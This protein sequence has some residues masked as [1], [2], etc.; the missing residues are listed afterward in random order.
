MPVR[1]TTKGSRI[2][3]KGLRTFQPSPALGTPAPFP[4]TIVTFDRA[5]FAL[6]D[7]DPDGTVAFVASVND[8]GGTY[9]ISNWRR[10]A[11]FT[12]I[13]ASGTGTTKSFTATGLGSGDIAPQTITVAA[14]YDGAGASGTVSGTITGSVSDHTIASVIHQFTLASTSGGNST[15][16][17]RLG[18]AFEAGD[19]PAGQKLAATVSGASVPMQ[20]VDTATWSDGSLRKATGIVFAGTVPAAGVDVVVGKASGAQGVSSFDPW[21]W[22]TSHAND[23]TVDI[24]NR[25]A[26][27]KQRYTLT[28][29]TGTFTVGESWAYGTATTT[30]RGTVLAWDGTNLDVLVT[31][32]GTFVPA[33]GTTTASA[34]TGMTSAAAGRIASITYLPASPASLAYSLKTAIGTV[35]RREIQE[36]AP[37]FVRAMAWQKVANEE[38]LV[39]IWYLDFWLNA[40]GT[41]PL[42]LEWTVVLS[43]HWAIANPFGVTQ[44]RDRQ[45]YDAVVKYGST[46]VDT[47]TDL[48]HAYHCRWASLRSANDDQHAKKHWVDLSG[49]GTGAMP[50]L[51]HA[52]SEAGLK[53]M[54][55]TGYLPPLRLTSVPTNYGANADGTPPPNGTY[56][57]LGTNGHKPAINGTGGY[58][59]RGA[60][61]VPDARAIITQTAT[62]WRYARAA[63]QGGM[64]VFWHTFDHRTPAVDKLIPEPF[65]QLGAKTYSGLG[66]ELLHG[67][68]YNNFGSLWTSAGGLMV[69]DYTGN[70]GSFTF[71]DY[72]SAH[73]PNYSGLM[74]FIEGERYLQDACLSGFEQVMSYSIYNESGHRKPPAYYDIAARR[75][76]Q[77]I[78]FKRYGIVPDL[79]QE[80]GD[81][82]CM[83]AM[84]WAWALCGDSNPHQAY[85]KNAIIN[86]DKYYKESFDYFPADHLAWGYFEPNGTAQLSAGSWLGNTTG[87]CAYHWLGTLEDTGLN[88]LAGFRKMCDQSVKRAVVALENDRF[89]SGQQ[90]RTIWP[91]D[92]NYMN[93]AHSVIQGWLA[94]HNATL[95]SST[96]TLAAAPLFGLNL[97]D[98]DKVVFSTRGVA[99]EVFTVPANFQLATVYYMRNVNGNSFQ[100]TTTPGSSGGTIITTAST[101]SVA[102]GMDQ[103]RAQQTVAGANTTYLPAGDSFT[104]MNYA[105]V[106]GAYAAGN[107]AVTPTIKAKVETFISTMQL[108]DWCAW[109]YDGAN[110]L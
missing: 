67:R 24:S 23:L 31:A 59:A 87:I 93:F 3:G 49:D 34:V 85:I 39:A 94:G 42:A 47:R 109:D 11:G 55:R 77:A 53:K 81:G 69:A 63:A 22:L 6:A 82:W 32:T 4:P 83:N 61:T 28:S 29:Q 16:M 18:L 41:A 100:L 91:C 52:Y 51:R 21:T 71:K 88:P 73:H 108:E 74:A 78:P 106:Q 76:A 7:N 45:I 60:V 89:I 57:P 99:F 92:N 38:H 96:F 50:T 8:G 107:P 86:L 17:H 25:K 70:S 27:S 44:Q 65:E 14:D 54:M 43:Q 97:Q 5:N 2:L 33:V 79:V 98:G 90:Y 104:S 13:G 36:N 35:A 68:N 40:L 19:V 20:A 95:A 9:T 84:I 37:R 30:A 48:N 12:K 15:G 72:D 62:D 64:S 75:T 10:T 26:W 110:A 56:T 66:A 101:G 1:I 80:R 105:A 102:I 103:Q 58:V 46:T